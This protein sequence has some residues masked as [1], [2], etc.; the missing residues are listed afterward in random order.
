MEYPDPPEWLSPEASTHWGDLC[1]RIIDARGKVHNADLN[2]IALACEHFADW[3]SLNVYLNKEPHYIEVGKNGSIQQHPA[4][5]QRR[6]HMFDYKACLVKLGL[7]SVDR[8]KSK[9]T[10][11]GAKEPTTGRKQKNVIDIKSSRF[12]KNG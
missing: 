6:Q 3:Q 10:K 1:A 7:T 12:A 4:V 9:D 5:S 8:S 11:P 2:I